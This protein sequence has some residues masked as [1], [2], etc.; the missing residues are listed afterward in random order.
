MVTGEKK[1]PVL[2]G[3]PSSDELRNEARQQ[4]QRLFSSSLFSHAHQLWPVLEAIVEQS[5]GNHDTIPSEKSIGRAVLGPTFDSTSDSTVRVRVRE[6]RNKLSQYYRGAGA[7]DPIEIQVPKG[8]YKAR[9]VRRKVGPIEIR[10]TEKSKPASPSK[11]GVVPFLTLVDGVSED[12][13]FNAAFLL[14][15]ILGSA[16]RIAVH[17][18]PVSLSAHGPD[19]LRE[20]SNSFGLSQIVQGTICNVD[21]SIRATVNLTDTASQTIT[22]SD[23]FECDIGDFGFVRRI[24]DAIASRFAHVEPGSLR[25]LIIPDNAIAADHYCRGVRSWAERT[26]R[27]VTE[28]EGHFRLAAAADPKHAATYAG[29]A[30]CAL[31]RAILGQRPLDLA[32]VAIEMAARAVGCDPDSAD[33]HAVLGAVRSIFQHDWSAAEAEYTVA[34]QLNPDSADLLGWYSG[35]LA[36]LGRADQATHTARR[37]EV[38]DAHSPF[39][40]AHV[41]KV[42]YFC[43]DYGAASSRFESIIAFAPQMDMA[44]GFLGMALCAGGDIARGICHLERAADLTGRADGYLGP[45]GHYLAKSGKVLRAQDI[46][47]EL[48]NR[49]AAGYVPATQIALVWAGL[50]Q[51]DKVF[52]CLNQAVEDNDFFLSLLKIWPP[53]QAVRDDPRFVAI[54]QRLGL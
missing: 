51:I 33:A 36:V 47:Q 31:F 29:L 4:L 28:A 43:G 22:W 18:S 41:A 10:P 5:L 16:P 12:F 8:G 46:A 40:T 37:L 52:R 11:I 45:L 32:P 20:I 7:G 23:G 26:P 19:G 3:S 35:H 21:G 42:F 49:A 9:F 34:A 30:N 13:G 14:S 27:S 25:H 53:F 6:I 17:S 54:L 39:I 1:Q 15:Q 2:S 44:H 50:G 24:A 38:L 48:E